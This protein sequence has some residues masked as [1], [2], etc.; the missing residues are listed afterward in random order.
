[1]ALEV[2]FAFDLR[3]SLNLGMGSQI[4]VEA[5]ATAATL[6]HAMGMGIVI[7][8]GVISDFFAGLGIYPEKATSAVN[9]IVVG[10]LV[11]RVTPEL[12]EGIAMP[13]GGGGHLF[14]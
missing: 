12:A 7:K 2:G 13:K 11:L 5:G 10:L 1:M 4:L 9:V 14:F 8:G 6:V 3:F